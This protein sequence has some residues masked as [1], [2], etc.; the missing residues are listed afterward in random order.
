MGIGISGFYLFHSLTHSLA[1]VHLLLYIYLY[2]FLLLMA[3]HTHTKI[4]SNTHKNE[5]TTSKF[6]HN[7]GFR[8]FLLLLFVAPKK[9]IYNSY[10]IYII[11]KLHNNNNQNIYINIF[12]WLK[13]RER[14]KK[15]RKF[16]LKWLFISISVCL[17]PAAPLKV[18]N[19]KVC[20]WSRRK[21]KQSI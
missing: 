21:M 8:Y 15:R 16:A 19:K 3:Q 9:N 13:T 18:S 11:E 14:K 5:N 2:T 17:L 7:N 10:K 6:Y 1:L 4:R 20:L 12:L